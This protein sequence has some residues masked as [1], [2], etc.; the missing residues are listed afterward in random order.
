MR[1]GGILKIIQVTL[2]VIAKLNCIIVW[3]GRCPTGDRLWGAGEDITGVICSRNNGRLKAQSFFKL[4]VALHE[5][6]VLQGEARIDGVEVVVLLG[7]TGALL[8][9]LKLGL[10]QVFQ[11]D[12]QLVN[13][14]LLLVSVNKINIQIQ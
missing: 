13:V 9:H 12:L 1:G 6:G 4:H 11:V 5:T 10:A 14:C 3:R 2:C 8:F 7:E